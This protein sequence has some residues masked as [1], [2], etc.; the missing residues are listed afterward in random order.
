MDLTEFIPV[1]LEAT[2]DAEVSTGLPVDEALRRATL[3]REAI[4]QRTIRP[5]DVER[6]TEFVE[7]LYA[8]SL[9]LERDEDAT[10]ERLLAD[11]EA[12][13]HFAR[14][15][16]WLGEGS[17]PLSRLAFLCWRNARRNGNASKESEWSRVHGQTSVADYRD[18][19]LS[20]RE[21]AEP[22]SSRCASSPLDVEQL[23][24]ICEGLRDQLEV[25][26]DHVS[27]ESA[28]LYDFLSTLNRESGR[29]D[30]PGYCLGELA[31]ICG[32]ANRVLSHRDEARR[33]FDRAE[34][35]FVLVRNSSVHV[36]RLAY[37]RLALRL[38]ERDFEAVMELAPRWVERFVELDL[39]ED[40][41]KCRFLEAHALKETERLDLAKTAFLGI[42]SDARLIGN[43]RLGAIAA[44][45][46]FQIHVFLGEID[47]AL[48]QAERATAT[49]RGLNNRVNLAKLQLGVGYFLRGQGRLGESIAAFRDAQRQFLEIQM[50]A[51]VAA[52]HLVL[53]DLFL[54]ANQPAQAER[55]I[56]AALPVID[57]LKLIPEGIAALSLLRDSV[58]RRQI[59]R[60]ALRSLTGY[61][62]ELGF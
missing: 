35:S 47:Q 46:L 42:E 7:V 61:F 19:L 37:Q 52:T 49:L 6:S 28:F 58:H 15:L 40:A 59:D 32:A 2:K 45:N 31:L 62:E 22:S 3:L 21:Y 4:R 44:Q 54:D 57:E 41:L 20:M 36:A 43:D 16:S 29:F 17:A 23:L 39:L 56:R 9:L 55:E 50:R 48:V 13:F 30:E 26:P 60:K 27:E 38:E 53:A 1:W 25:S 18:A 12:V 14:A 33:W 24:S 51:D 10:P 5:E 8:L 34:A 11:C